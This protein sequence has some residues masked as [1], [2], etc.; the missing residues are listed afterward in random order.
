M[1]LLHLRIS[2]KEHSQSQS[3]HI[4]SW[5][6]RAWSQELGRRS[7][8]MRQPK[9]FKQNEEAGEI[10]SVHSCVGSTVRNEMSLSYRE[11]HP[12]LNSLG[13]QSLCDQRQ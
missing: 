6:Q 10:R 9:P 5:S 1:T 2:R 12:T 8:C 7:R 11:S 13:F 3:I 4:M